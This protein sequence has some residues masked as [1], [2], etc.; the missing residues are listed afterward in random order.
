MNSERVGYRYSASEA[1]HPAVGRAIRKLRKQLGYSPEQFAVECEVSYGTI[2]RIERGYLPY[3]PTFAK[4]ASTLG[5]TMDQLF[6]ADE[7]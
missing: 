1:G 2:Q 4:I 3:T 5:V 6:Y 7:P